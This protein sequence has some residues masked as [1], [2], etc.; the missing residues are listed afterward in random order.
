MAHLDGSQNYKLTMCRNVSFFAMVGFLLWVQVAR[1]NWR[2][3]Q[4]V[5]WRWGMRGFPVHQ[6]FIRW[7]P[8]LCLSLLPQ[9]DALQP[10]PRRPLKHTKPPRPPTPTWPSRST[11]DASRQRSTTA[12]KKVP[13]DPQ[14][15]SGNYVLNGRRSDPF[16]GSRPTN[17][18]RTALLFFLVIDIT[19]GKLTKNKTPQV[20]PLNS[21][22]VQAN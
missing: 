12:G 10:T 15:S 18:L 7:F 4:L 9:S 22:K 20:W 11:L 1:W 8:F 21:A 5:S 16:Q 6:L 14:K 17:L 2:Q 19:H 13:D 3:V